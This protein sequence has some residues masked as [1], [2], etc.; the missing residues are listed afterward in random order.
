MISEKN[1]FL[2]VLRKYRLLFLCTKYRALS[3]PPKNKNIFVKGA[4]AIGRPA[5]AQR[6]AR[7]AS[8]DRGSSA[9]REKGCLWIGC[10]TSDIAKRWVSSLWDCHAPKGARNDCERMWDCH[11]LTRASGGGGGK[12]LL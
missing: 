3:N 7:M 1:R 9:L 4:K 5:H 8:A 6:R 12:C 2:V 10:E 11:G